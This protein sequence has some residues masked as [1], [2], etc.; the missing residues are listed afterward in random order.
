MCHG[1]SCPEGCLAPQPGC[2]HKKI[3]SVPL[4]SKEFTY[5]SI[6]V[7]SKHTFF[8]HLISCWLKSRPSIPILLWCLVGQF[9][10]FYSLFTVTATDNSVCFASLAFTTCA[11][12]YS[13]RNCCHGTKTTIHYIYSRMILSQ[14]IDCNILFKNRVADRL[15]MYLSFFIRRS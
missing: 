11:A 4:R 7:C 5:S 3:C 8:V 14:G 2:T 6:C 13:Q 1:A 15:D 12:K 9:E 10:L